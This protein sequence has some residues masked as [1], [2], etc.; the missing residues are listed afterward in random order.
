M[1][2]ARDK[3]LNGTPPSYQWYPRDF[4][5][6][7]AG[8]PPLAELAYRRA[9]DA[10]WMCQSYG[11]GSESDWMVWSQSTHVDWPSVRPWILRHVE[12]QPDGTWAQ[13]RMAKERME[14]ELYHR[15][16]KNRPQNGPRVDPPSDHS[17]STVD[18]LPLQS[19]SAENLHLHPSP[20]G[21]GV[22]ES[23]GVPEK[24]EANPNLKDWMEAFPEFW[25]RYP[26][27]VSKTDAERA[28]AKIKPW[29]QEQCDLIFAGLDFYQERIWPDR[30]PD[31]IEYPA[32]WL[33]K[34]RFDDAAEN[35]E[36]E[37]PES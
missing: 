32:T 36:G 25:R 34:R 22:A 9:L 18:L 16:M 19:A 24:G 17:E 15:R 6:S 2:R 29:T 26:R 7:V 12:V 35:P 13:V 11:V 21:D 8:M 4:A 23:N 37:D 27:K 14:Q 28:Y 33:N 10:S 30:S 5:A 20:S 1:P 31:K 3:R